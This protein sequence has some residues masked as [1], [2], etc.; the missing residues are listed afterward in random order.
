[1]REANLKLVRSGYEAFTKGDFETLRTIFAPDILWHGPGI[2]PFET[3]YKG[4]ESVLG[5]FTKLF[6]LT[7]G[8][9][10]VDIEHMYADDDRVVVLQLVSGSRHGVHVE[11]RDVVVYEIVG[12]VETAVTQYEVD[13]KA[14][15][16][17]FS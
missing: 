8:T 16:A 9:I 15:E 3:D 5:Y 7:E 10:R 12:G 17:M 11:F 2:E 13:L 14:I 1:M 6:E 4:V